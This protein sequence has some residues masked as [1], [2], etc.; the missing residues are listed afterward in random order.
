MHPFPDRRKAQL[1]DGPS[2]V[3]VVDQV[4]AHGTCQVAGD[5]QTE[6]DRSGHAGGASCGK[7]GMENKVGDV[8]GNSGPVVCIGNA[9][10]N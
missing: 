7:V 2:L 4:A 3:A 5:C 10:F 9:G 8:F 6:T 1:E